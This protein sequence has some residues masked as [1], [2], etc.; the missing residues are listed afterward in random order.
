[1]RISRTLY[2]KRG[3]A[4]FSLTLYLSEIRIVSIGMHCYL[5]DNE[6]RA[7]AKRKEAHLVSLL[8]NKIKFDG[9]KQM[10]CAGNDVCFG[11]RKDRVVLPVKSCFW[12]PK[13][14]LYTDPAES[15]N[16]VQCVVSTVPRFS[17]LSVHTQ[18]PAPNF[19]KLPLPKKVVWKFDKDL[20]RPDYVNCNSVPGYKLHLNY[21]KTHI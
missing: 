16:K 20:P 8:C 19:Y 17:E 3:K 18:V 5:E 14:S 21:S 12:D 15:F 10:E 11:S 9:F 4:L 7:R 2:S 6:E 1:M 13:N